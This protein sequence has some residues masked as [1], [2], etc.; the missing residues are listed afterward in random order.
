MNSQFEN[1]RDAV[2]QRLLIS[3]YTP[4]TCMYLYVTYIEIPNEGRKDTAQN[5]K[6]E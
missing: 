2:K 5:E 6:S 3:M 1:D 4:L